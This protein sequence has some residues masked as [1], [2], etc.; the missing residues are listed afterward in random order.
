MSA[1]P[2]NLSGVFCREAALAEL[3]GDVR[4]LGELSAIFLGEWPK[5]QAE[6]RAALAEEGHARL[7]LTAHT[8]KAAVGL[9]GGP[10][11]LAAAW[12]LE[13]M[14]REGN[15]HGAAAALEALEQEIDRLWPALAAIARPVAGTGDAG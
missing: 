4:L 15:R 10:L 6:L 9:L 1:P 14:S 2:H 8:I 11:A 5:W 7:Q 3:D 12:K 13:T